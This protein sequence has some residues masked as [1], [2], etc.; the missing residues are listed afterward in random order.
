M[1][2][3]MTKKAQEE[4]LLADS[5]QED[6][7]RYLEEVNKIVEFK[8]DIL[9]RK[10][11][12]D[13]DLAEKEREL[14]E[15]TKQILQ[16]RDDTDKSAL[17]EKKKKVREELLELRDFKE[18]KCNP[19]IKGMLREIKDSYKGKAQQENSTINSKIRKLV[20]QYAE[21]REAYDEE[22]TRK[23]AATNQ[24][25]RETAF[26]KAEREANRIIMDKGNW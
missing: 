21:K 7:E 17:M 23:I 1:L 11:T 4:T 19:I 13:G 8:N 12:V 24:L 10:R 14:A 5:K 6:S 20:D 2:K 26:H 15:L 22:L 3:K 25:S 16:N 9:R 18:T